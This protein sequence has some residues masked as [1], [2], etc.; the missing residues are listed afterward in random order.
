MRYESTYAKRK[1]THIKRG[2]PQTRVG[3]PR[4]GVEIVGPRY[5]LE[6]HAY[7]LLGVHAIY[8]DV[9]FV[10]LLDIHTL[11]I[12]HSYAMTGSPC[13]LNGRSR[14]YVGRSHIQRG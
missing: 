1:S 11:K 7:E 12:G 5:C 14:I 8:V 13:V 6:S 4:L 10:R 3:T 9:Q 2:H